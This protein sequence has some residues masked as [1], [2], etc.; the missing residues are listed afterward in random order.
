MNCNNC[1]ESLNKG[2]KFC[3]VCGSLVTPDFSKCPECGESI[4]ENDRFCRTCGHKIDRESFNKEAFISSNKNS[5]NVNDFPNFD[6]FDEEE[7]NFDYRTPYDDL[8]K[9]NSKIVRKSAFASLLSNFGKKR[10]KNSVKSK[11][12]HRPKNENNKSVKKEDTSVE[13]AFIREDFT[14]ELP[15]L[16]KVDESIETRK[17]LSDKKKKLLEESKEKAENNENFILDEPSESDL[18]QTQK[19]DLSEIQRIE[20]EIR[21][22]RVKEENKKEENRLNK[23]IKAKEKN[24][25]EKVQKVS[26][27]SSSKARREKKHTDDKGQLGKYLIPFL[28]CLA[29]VFASGAYLTAKTSKNSVIENFE[30]AVINKDYAK[31]ASL[32]AKSD[33]SPIE[34]VEIQSFV[35]LMN[36]NDIFKSSL[37]G[38]I[39]EDSIKLT[40]NSDYESNRVYRLE[41][42]G[43]KYLFFNDY[44]IVL[45]TVNINLTADEGITYTFAG[46]E[47]IGSASEIMLIPGKYILSQEEDTFDVNVSNTNPNFDSGVLVVD[48]NDLDF[49]VIDAEDEKDI[50]EE[51]SELEKLDIAGDVNLYLESPEKAQVYI[52]GK[53]TGLSVGEFNLLDGVNIKQGDKIQVKEEFPW[54]FSFS[55]E[56]TYEGENSIYLEVNLNSEDNMQVIMEKVVQLLK[57]DEEARQKMSMNPFTSI[58]EPELSSAKS[59]IDSE[60]DSDIIYYRDYKSMEFDPDSFD[61]YS[62]DDGSYTAYIGGVITYDTT[63]V[64]PEDVDS[65]EGQEISE[66]RGFH[67]TH[68]PDKDW[69]VNLWGYTERYINTDNLIE[70]TVD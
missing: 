43:K 26:P 58:I 28:L 68:L 50:T 61:I 5:E 36:E 53:D 23:D 35:K 2:D 37:M 16:S 25:K 65:V 8:Y 10:Y 15:D 70:V 30:N 13:Q 9:D 45:D 64:S 7:V 4:K 6:E 14:S 33:N 1:G 54:G 24:K 21:K 27:K 62:N 32:I 11:K 46:K 57:E 51:E 69:F 52:N 66:I 42:V 3:K 22:V 20:T 49:A 17:K 60:V 39:K 18:M 31:T 34:E 67:L 47:Y 63:E 12:T 55:D 41:K 40:R 29:L 59:L 44:R 48:I 19:I 38:A 56:Y